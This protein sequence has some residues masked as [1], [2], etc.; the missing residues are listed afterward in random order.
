MGDLRTSIRIDLAGN[1]ER[2]AQRYGQSLGR[3]SERGQ[4]DL[5]RLSRAAVALGR[6]LDRLTGRYTQMLG[7]AA[8]AYAGARAVIESA[9][10]DKQLTQ[11]R[12][13]AGATVQMAALL[14]EEL[15]TMAEQTGQSMDSL[16]GGFNNLVQA[17]LEWDQ[18]LLTIKAINPA[19]AVTGAQAEVLSSA[20]TVAAKAFEF[21]LAQP[22]L[23]AELLDQMTVAG[24]LGNAELEDLSGIFARVGI[25]AKAANLSFSE[26]LGFI[27]QLSL[28]ERE[29]E[30]LAT[31]ADSTLRLFTNQK[32]LEQAA[33]VTGVSFY[34]ADDQRRAAFDVLDDIA[35]K[36]KQ[37]G[38]DMD[39]DKAL[40][41]A[42]GN[43]DLDTLKGLRALLSGDAI[44]EAR[45]MSREISGSPGTIGKDLEDALANSVDQVA[46]LKRAL[47]S[48]ADAF[49][50]PVNDAIERAIQYLMD[51]KQLGGKELLLGA[52]GTAL[53]GFGLL[54]G[55]G[56]LL[57]RFGGVG[58]GVVA[59]KALEEVAGVQPVYVVNMPG[60]GFGGLPGVGGRGLPGGFNPKRFGGF[61]AGAALLG[62][63]RLSQLGLLGAGAVGTAGVVAAGAG[64]AG[65][66]FG[67]LLNKGLIEGT[68]LGD[69]IGEGIA[70]ALAL[71]GNDEARRAVTA[72]D[73][74]E[75]RGELRISIDQEGRARV[76]QMES[77][78]LDMEV[79]AG[80]MMMGP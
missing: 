79:E 8:G 9:K 47:G 30:R 19:M 48:A 34:D 44:A 28:I 2:R 7:G 27:E 1:L 16:L 50:Q 71:F 77:R 55:S 65:Y 4:R 58:A 21:D 43:V 45:A 22:K 68:A 40:S 35:A 36:Y 54:K 63:T 62:G 60:G 15:H 18:A 57:Q 26:T 25:N 51:D 29:P 3:F 52:A 61:R 24:R 39:R 42:F 59:G 20:M 80:L 37:L 11:I 64:A 6:G 12:Q 23:A 49:A 32:Y 76:R 69:T 31:L 14:R 66:G 70:R 73:Q 33:K 10:L 67:T 78:G 74:A 38:S 5:G 17:G 41:S 53:A 46:R 56:K 75:M 13:T 72:T